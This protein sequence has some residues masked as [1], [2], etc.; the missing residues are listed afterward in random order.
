LF[1]E[2][3]LSKLLSSIVELMVLVAVTASLVLLFDYLIVKCYFESVLNWNVVYTFLS[4]VVLE[5]VAF[6]LIG[7]RFLQEKVEV[8]RESYVGDMIIPNMA[9]KPRLK[10]VRK[11]RPRLGRTLIGAG[12][13]LFIVGMFILPGYYKL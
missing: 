10:V 7:V 3:S 12:I 2:K 1:K 11:A 9:Y 13:V 6:I 5:G 4:A 8:S